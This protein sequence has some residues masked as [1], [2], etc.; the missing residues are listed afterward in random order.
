MAM[1]GSRATGTV[2]GPRG[3]DVFLS[4]KSE[5]K[6]WVE[7][8]ARSLQSAGRSVFLDIWNL[9]PGESWVEGLRRGVEECRA[10]VLIATPDVVNSGWIREEYNALLQRR[11]ARPDFKP[12]RTSSSSP[13]SSAT[14]R[15]C[16]SC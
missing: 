14:F 2:P 10:A 13:S 11:Q 7:W 1:D 6:P 4:Y 5:H 8:L 15:T 9:V 3:Y 12:G 16:R